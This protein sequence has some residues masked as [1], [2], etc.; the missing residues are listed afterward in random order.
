[1]KITHNK[2]NI[3]VAEKLEDFTIEYFEEMGVDYIQYQFTTIFGVLIT[4]GLFLS[5]NTE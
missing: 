5:L 2:V 3:M 1:M 4:R